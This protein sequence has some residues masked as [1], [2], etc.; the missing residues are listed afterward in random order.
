MGYGVWGMACDAGVTA[1]WYRHRMLST[2]TN[3]RKLDVWHDGIELVAEVYRV[4]AQFP[5]DERYGLT[6]QIRR[7]A[8]SVPSNI[9]EGYGRATRGEYLNALSVAAGS[10]NEVET[11]L[12]VCLSLGVGNQSE[13]D[14]LTSQTTTLQKRLARLRTT[15]KQ[16]KGA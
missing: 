14:A 16:R 7:A 6:A 11:L 15:L 4:S 13:L 2:R 3:F 8:V 12:A 5:K 9:A 10:L 1:R